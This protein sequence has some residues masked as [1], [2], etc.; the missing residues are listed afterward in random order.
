[1]QE[2]LLPP[3]C[4][5]GVVTP[6]K[7]HVSLDWCAFTVLSDFSI[8]DILGM[9]ENDFFLAPRSGLGYKKLQILGDIKVFSDGNEGMGVH[10]EMSGEGCRQYEC[11][12]EGK[13]WLLILEV[14]KN[15]GHF[16]RIDLALDDFE[17]ILSFDNILRKVK[18]AH[19]L[20]RFKSARI[21]T[22]H[23][24]SD[25]SSLGKTVYFGSEKSDIQVR[26][27]DKLIQMRN[28][29]PDLIPINCEHWIRF[30]IQ[31]RD[32]RSDVIADFILNEKKKNLGELASSI[33]KNYICFVNPNK[34]DEHRDRW[35]VCVWWNKFL[36]NAEKLPIY[37]E[38][39][40]KSYP[41]VRDWII[42]QVAPSLA[43]LSSDLNG[44][45]DDLTDIVEIVKYGSLRLDDRKYDLIRQKKILEKEKEA[46]K[47]SVR[48]LLKKI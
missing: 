28:K 11:I 21:L 8:F 10:V 39:R 24:L 23:D 38:P 26:C 14:Q 17:K 25:A 32:N 47:A 43:V 48:E 2:N 15:C 5:T 1:M 18:S 20:S 6:L 7:N 30:E 45:L 40:K 4:N 41:E 36:D 12:N 22:K 29:S 35:P 13:W 34:S 37:I 9:P 31:S 27:Y 44:N 33:L 46:R 42:R 3:T 16:T 19:V